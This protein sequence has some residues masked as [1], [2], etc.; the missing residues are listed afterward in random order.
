VR[1]SVSVR[2]LHFIGVLAV[3]LPREHSLQEGPMVIGDVAESLPE[4]ACAEVV[5]ACVGSVV[6][7]MGTKRV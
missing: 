1:L 6:T 7:M 5:V 3:A 4:F 2:L